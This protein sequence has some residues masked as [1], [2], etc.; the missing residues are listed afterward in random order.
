VYLHQRVY[1]S[2]LKQ[3]DYIFTDFKYPGIPEIDFK[4]IENEIFTINN[5]LITP[6]EVL[7]YKLP[8]FG[9]RI[10]DFTYITDAN[11]I[12]ETEIAKARGSKAV[13]LNALRNEPH[14][15]HF[16]LKEAIEKA[17]DINAPN[18]Y[19]THMSHQI[20]FHNAVNSQ[21]PKGMELAYDGLV[22][23]L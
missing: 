23:N 13:V 1:N 5:T 20:G 18:T 4:L 11:F 14:I 19:F 10:Y 12:S 7:H 17:K 8:V 22:L 21:L 15:S 16:T 2:F 3:Y 6:I 9:F